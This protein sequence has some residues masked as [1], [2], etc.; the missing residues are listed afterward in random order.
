MIDYC[1]DSILKAHSINGLYML[2]MD[3]VEEISVLLDRKLPSGL[4]S[5]D[6]IPFFNILKEDFFK[7]V[8]NEQKEKVIKWVKKWG[9]NAEVALQD[10]ESR[11][12][13]LLA[14]P[15]WTKYG[16]RRR[17]GYSADVADILIRG[18]ASA[19]AEALAIMNN[20]QK[21]DEVGEFI[22]QINPN[23]L[24]LAGRKKMYHMLRGHFKDIYFPPFRR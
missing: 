3:E 1:N 9:N 5:H 10:G 8:D 4:T 16:G 15:H 7:K 14:R 21:I 6:S 11:E 13:V 23:K 22:N 18:K 20:P 12:N 2:T 19:F 24:Y 17:G